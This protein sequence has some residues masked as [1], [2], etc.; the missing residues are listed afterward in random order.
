[1]D[2]N[3]F[4]QCLWHILVEFLSLTNLD[5]NFRSSKDLLEGDGLDLIFT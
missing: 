1:M 3:E 2:Y 4:C 5:E